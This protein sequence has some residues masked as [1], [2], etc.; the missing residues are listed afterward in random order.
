MNVIQYQHWQY[1][2]LIDHMEFI[3]M[4]NRAYVTLA[5]ISVHWPCRLESV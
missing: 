2:I 1:V 4:H 5:N 3:H